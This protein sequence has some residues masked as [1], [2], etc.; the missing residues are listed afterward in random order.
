MPRWS[1]S[2]W[3]AIGVTVTFIA[4]TSWW[5]TV[6][7]SIPV[8]D[9]GYHLNTAISY[10]EM[11]SSGDLLGPYTH[12]V[13][14][15]PFAYLVGA[16]AMLIGGV[17]LSA[18]VIG[19]NLVFVPLLTLGCYQ[20]GRLLFGRSA[21]LLAVIFVLGSPL[22]ISQF[23]VFMLDA[24]LTAMVAVS[25]WL[26]LASEDFSRIA[27]SGLAGVAAGCGSLVKVTFP[28]FIAGIVLMAL[29]RG[30]WRNWRGLAA[31]A[32]AALVIA[33][34]WYLDHVAEFSNFTKFAGTNSGALPT[35]LP[36]TLST[37]NL[38]WYFWDT[39]NYQ[40]VAWLFLLVLGGLIWTIHAV[41]K[42]KEARVLR[43]ELLVGF[44]VAWLAITLTPHKDLRYA[45]GLMPYLAVIGTGWIVH[46]PRV[47]RLAA[48]A[49]LV[50]AV[51]ANTLGSTFGVGEAVLVSLSSRPTQ[52][53]SWPD[54]IVLYNTGAFG[55]AGPQRDGDVPGLLDALRASGVQGVLLNGAQALAPP[56]DELGLA[57]LLTV[58]GLTGSPDLGAVN[59]D[60]VL[61]V[62]AHPATHSG[63]LACARLDDGS[64]VYVLR[65]N[66]GSHRVELYCP[67]PHPHFYS[68]GLPQNPLSLALA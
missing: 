64:S 4:L 29:T 37:A 47:A 48:T 21:G 11:L 13:Q 67:F 20:T 14:Y 56:F 58:A 66:P 12:A 38:G 33:A 36:P 16:L 46:I 43:A 32:A 42:R 9:A 62:L 17:N 23:H 40:L 59:T 65:L 19:E 60:P 3:G 34:P 31:F 68:T 45:M 57:P 5:L 44:F 15:P 50:L 30:G 6:D 7:R 55:I 10:R 49:V 18:P 2:A 61:A 41:V 24:P 54:R 27:V 25:L 53:S 51:G 28:L 35:E 26:L 63:T 1:V 39:L 22:L 8:S 52:V